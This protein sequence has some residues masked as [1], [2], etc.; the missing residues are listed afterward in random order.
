VQPA[1]LAMI[2]GTST[3]V[4]HRGSLAI[5][6]ACAQRTI[7]GVENPRDVVDELRPNEGCGS[8]YFRIVIYRPTPTGQNVFPSHPQVSGYSGKFDV[9]G[10]CHTVVTEPEP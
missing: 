8:A 10:R 4:G 7:E 3:L 2:G 9:L 5:G 1:V 6:T